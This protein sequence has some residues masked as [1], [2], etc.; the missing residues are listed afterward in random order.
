MANEYAIPQRA[1]RHRRNWDNTPGC[2]LL[3]ISLEVP[4][5]TE[6]LCMAPDVGVWFAPHMKTGQVKIWRERETGTIKKESERESL[7]LFHPL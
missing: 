6:H 1:L 3:W 5:Y 4:D 7:T 2:D